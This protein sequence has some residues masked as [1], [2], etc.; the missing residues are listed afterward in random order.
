MTGVLSLRDVLTARGAVPV[1]GL[2]EKRI[3]AV[4]PDDRVGVIIELFGKYGFATVPVTD[5][6]GVLH[7][8]ITLHDAVAAA[9]PDFV[10]D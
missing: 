10:K 7:G 9:S 2:M 6:Q 4:R 5:D 3:I 1:G 8:V